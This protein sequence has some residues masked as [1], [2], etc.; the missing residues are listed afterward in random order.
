[1]AI[2][3]DRG[4]QSEFGENFCLNAG[5]MVRSLLESSRVESSRV[6][7]EVDSSALA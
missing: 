1:M 3:V 7:V 2:S 5:G 6:D 4:K